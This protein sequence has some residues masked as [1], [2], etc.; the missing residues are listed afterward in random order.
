MVTSHSNICIYTTP[1]LYYTL[2]IL[3]FTMNNIGGDRAI[4]TSLSNHREVL[5]MNVSYKTL[6]GD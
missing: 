3:F 1:L 4:E 2:L 6:L 5:E